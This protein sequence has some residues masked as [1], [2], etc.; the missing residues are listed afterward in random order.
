[1]QNIISWSMLQS[2]IP[3]FQSKRAL[4]TFFLTERHTACVAMPMINMKYKLHHIIQKPSYRKSLLR[5]EMS[6]LE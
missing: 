3:D 5:R 2:H 6:A 1:M 4:L